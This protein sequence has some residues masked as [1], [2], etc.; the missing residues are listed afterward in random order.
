MGTEG[1][2][3]K[4]GKLGSKS[5]TGHVARRDSNISG[6]GVNQALIHWASIDDLVGET[7]VLPD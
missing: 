1:Y 4:S 3:R 2:H 6:F 5:V 7:T